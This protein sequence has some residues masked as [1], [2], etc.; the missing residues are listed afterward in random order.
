MKIEVDLY[1][2]IRYLYTQEQ[3]SQREISRRLGVS[4]KTVKKYCDGS[5]VPWE[6]NGCSGRTAYVIT[7]DIIHF[8]EACLLEDEQEKIKKQRHTSKRIYDR[9]VEE[10][11]FKGGESTI[12]N[13]IAEM[14]D[15]PKKPFL[16]LSY[17]P[18]E[19]IQIDWGEATIYLSGKKSKVNLFCMRQ[20]YSSDIFVKA[21][22]RQNEESFLEGIISGLEYFKG[23]PQKIIFDN[24]RVAVKDGFGAHAK[25]QDKYRLLAAHYAFKTEFCN[26]ASGHEKGLVEGLVGWIR[27]NVLV[28]IPRVTSIE[29]LNTSILQRCITYKKHHIKGKDASVGEMAIIDHAAFSPLAPYRFDSSKVMTAKVDEFSTVKFDYNYYSVPVKYVGKDISI[30]GFGN[31]ISILYHKDEI[32]RYTR[33]Y[34][35]NETF[36]TLDH[37]IDLL[38]KRPRSVYNAKPVK[39]AISLEL[40]EIGKS[41]GNHRDMVK[42]LRLCVDYGEL[43]VINAVKRVSNKETVSI[44]QI[45]AYLL[46][47]TNVTPLP[48][49]EDVTVKSTNLSKY[50]MLMQEVII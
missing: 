9:L 6:R 11:G 34:T 45:R 36:Y 3:L 17:E 48:M 2:K 43:N 28:P 38:E 47:T 20:C 39:A 19:A 1:E 30:K 21:F 25:V 24:A 37:Y 5:A 27:R 12:R 4:R 22:F 41:L 29:E 35:R 16:P 33:S 42:L 7:D 49:L 26:V 31:T 15:A 14:K 23:V 46:P 13:I 50:D 8:I 10:K 44:D 40:I 18:G 32:A